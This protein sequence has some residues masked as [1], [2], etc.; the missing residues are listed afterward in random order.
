M[1][2]NCGCGPA[3]S[4]WGWEDSV[5]KTRDLSGEIED[6][7]KQGAV[8]EAPRVARSP[9]TFFLHPEDKKMSVD[10]PQ[11]SAADRPGLVDAGRKIE[12][13]SFR[14]ID[15]EIGEHGFSQ[16]EWQVVRRV[17]HTSG[18][19]DFAN[20]MRFHPQAIE[21]AVAALR[22]GC[23]IFTDTRMI[24]AGLSPW[25]LGWFG[26]R[27]ETPVLDPKS[28]EWAQKAGTTRSVAAFSHYGARFNGCIVAIGNA[29]TALLETIRLARE[30]GVR[31][32]LIVGVPV[33]FVQAAESKQELFEL[34]DRPSITVLGRK[35][36][37]SIAVA[38]LHALFE[39]A[40]GGVR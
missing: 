21:S 35:G 1:D 6:Q 2:V 8:L 32:A 3:L 25:R 12:Q 15:S 24:H 36:G 22:G 39:L 14:I 11:G 10:P 16:D 33:G 5:G 34:D 27:V 37:S 7:V 9:R 19:F 26:N 17:I 4:G 28:Q 38:I 23:T 18:D 13:E 20:W 29:P 31:P 30:E 40:K